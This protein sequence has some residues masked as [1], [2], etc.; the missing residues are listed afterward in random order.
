MQKRKTFLETLSEALTHFAKTGYVSQTELED[1][2]TRLRLS[3][4]FNLKPMPDM[5]KYVRKVMENT[6]NKLVLQNGITKQSQFVSRFTIDKIKPEL[7][8]E[9]NRRILASTSLI[10][11]NRDQCVEMVLRRF[12]GWAT[13]QPPGGSKVGSKDKGKAKREISTPY[14]RLP[15]QERRVVIDQNHKLS[16]TINDLV[17]VSGGAIA[18]VWH[19]HV[20]QP[21]YDYRVTHAERNDKFYLIRNSWAQQKGL[22]K[23][24]KAGYTDEI[25]QPG[26]E[27]YCRCYYRYI[28]SLNRLPEEMLTKKGQASIA[29]FGK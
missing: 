13:A 1:W 26:E 5:E 11:L 10:K 19:S 8:S 24:G 21:G 9:L 14:Q 20:D 16:A 27:V 6:Y 4:K 25:T 18:A 28:Y 2:T 15:F 22:V 3:L 17:A 12:Q 23:P 29:A 7:H